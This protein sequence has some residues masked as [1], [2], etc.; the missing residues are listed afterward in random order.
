M[1]D[2][3]LASRAS[4]LAA[5]CFDLDDTLFDYE[6]Y[7]EAGL[8]EAAAVIE[9][10]TGTDF[11]PELLALYFEEDVRDGTFDALLDR[12]DL[13]GELTPQ[14]VEAYHDSSGPLTPYDETETVLSTLGDSYRLGLITDGR[15]ARS[16][17]RRLGLTDHFETVFEGPAHGVDKTDVRPF[18]DVLS[19]LDV[20]PEDTLYVGDNPHTDFRHPNDLGMYTVR[21]R[22]G[23]YV[24][25]DPR[26]GEAPDHTIDS[27]AELLELVDD[28]R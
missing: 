25:R 10:E 14:L 7:I 9:S 22:R 23:R 20:D 4:S 24:D 19:E 1:A 6:Q 11:E 13:P 27:L 2:T 18:L 28:A 17:L 8:R 15:N 5:I 26:D 21:L 3:Q 16:K 12:H